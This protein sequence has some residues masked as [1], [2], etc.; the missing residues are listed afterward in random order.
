MIDGH[1]QIRFATYDRHPGRAQREPGIQR[2]QREIP[3]SSLRD[4]P[5]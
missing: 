4:A 5:E 3:G 1:R 2:L